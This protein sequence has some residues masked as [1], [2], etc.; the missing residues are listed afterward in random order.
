MFFF[1]DFIV[2]QTLFDGTFGTTTPIS[3]DGTMT[4]TTSTMISGVTDVTT[5]G[6]DDVTT[7]LSDSVL[8][9]T[10][11][12]VAVDT[13][14]SPVITSNFHRYIRFYPYFGF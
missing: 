4:F 13:A 5:D 6:V 9:E 14:Y 1:Q 2:P 10:T 12:T 11:T 7:L 8:D 3:T